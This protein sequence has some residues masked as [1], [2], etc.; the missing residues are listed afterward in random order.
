MTTPTASELTSYETQVGL[1]LGA[2]FQAQHTEKVNVLTK[3]M[4]PDA[5]HRFLYLE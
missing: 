5:V 3:R 1:G 2:R 4:G